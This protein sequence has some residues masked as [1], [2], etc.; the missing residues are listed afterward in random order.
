MPPVVFKLFAGQG[1]G[2]TDG[3][4]GDIKTWTNTTSMLTPVVHCYC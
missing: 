4:N 2:W 3:Q 1:T